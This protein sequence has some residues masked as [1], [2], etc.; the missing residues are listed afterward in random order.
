MSPGTSPTSAAGLF[1]STE[2][3]LTPA[4]GGVASGAGTTPC[5]ALEPPTE[6][7]S[8]AATFR[9]LSIGIAKPMPWAPAR[10]ATFTPITSPSMFNNGP[11]E[12]PG[13]MLASV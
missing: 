12:L 1:F 5:H 10:T 9:A 7:K 6:A 4:C 13:L 8:V 2:A 11:P 3:T